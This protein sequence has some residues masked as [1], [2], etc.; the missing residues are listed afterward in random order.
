MAKEPHNYKL[1][2]SVKSKVLAM[3]ARGEKYGT[4][5]S[6]LKN[7]HNIDYSVSAL[8]DLR[9]RNAEAIQQMTEMIVDAEAT[10]AEKIRTRALRKVN[11]TLDRADADEAEL[12]ALEEEYRQPDSKM[13]LAEYRRRKT[14]LLRLSVTDLLNITDR[15]HNQTQKLKATGSPQLP[16]GNGAPVGQSPQLAEALLAA[17]QN[18]DTIT[19]QQMEINW[20]PCL[21]RQS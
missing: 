11:R 8:A 10:E 14:G 12:Q 21:M 3:M 13:T 7:D 19:L 1:N 4:I 9:K 2:T 6:V 20:T 15:M 18:G 16:A 5:V 17:I